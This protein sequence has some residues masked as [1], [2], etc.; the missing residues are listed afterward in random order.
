MIKIVKRSAARASSEMI[1]AR[2]L[3]YLANDAHRNHQNKELS[4]ATDKQGR[5]S[6]PRLFIE[7]IKRTRDKYIQYR[8]GRRGKR[9]RRLF[10]EIV[11]SSPHHAFLTPKERA[12]AQRLIANSMAPNSP[13]HAVW[14]TD[15][16][17]GRADLHV[18]VSTVTSDFP[19]R[20]TIWSQFGARKANIF[21]S[22]D[23]LDDHIAA[24]INNFRPISE[25]VKSRLQVRAEKSAP[26]KKMHPPLAEEIARTSIGPIATTNVVRAIQVAGHRV[27][28]VTPNFISVL[29]IGSKRPR[30]FNLNSLLEDVAS[31]MHATP[32][33]PQPSGNLNPKRASVPTPTLSPPQPQPAAPTRRI[34]HTHP[35]L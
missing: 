17:T 21:T 13:I 24:A 30:R 22:L 9:T 34:K 3:A 19:P 2:R 10:E 26:Y 11:Y 1:L 23:A 33:M 20:T 14:H 32:S 7:R 16:L 28:R 6:S 15:K 27:T 12:T 5:I 31:A 4:K 35:R 25:H 29:F 18:I 8:E